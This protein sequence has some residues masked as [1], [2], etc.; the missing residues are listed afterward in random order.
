MKEKAMANDEYWLQE[1]PCDC[2]A[3]FI[4]KLP[5]FAGGS[6]SD[7]FTLNCTLCGKQ[8]RTVLPATKIEYE[9]VPSDPNGNQ[10]GKEKV[11]NTD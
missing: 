11:E 3:K 10:I 7:L 6:G 5:A 1:I 2:G 8:K 9:C 4:V